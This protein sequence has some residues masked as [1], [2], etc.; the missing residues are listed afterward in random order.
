MPSTAKNTA[1][2]LVYI[3]S[4]QQP[5]DML[6]AYGLSSVQ[7]PRLD[8]LAE[9]GLLFDHAISN[10]PICT[11]A[12]GMMITGQHPLWNNCF[13]NERRLATDIGQS[14]AEVTGDAGY[15]N[16]YVGKWHLLGGDRDRPVPEGEDRHGFDDLFLTNNCALNY[17]PDNAF[18]WD[19]DQKRYFG[20]WEVEGQTDQAIDFI[21][22]QTDTQPFSLF[23]S[24]HAPHNHDGGDAARYSSFDAPEEFKDLYDPENP[25]SV[26]IR[27]TIPSNPRTRRMMQGYMALCTEVDHNVG[28]II[29]SLEEQGLLDN[30]II[31]YTSD[32]GETFGAFDNFA[33]KGSP[34]DASTRVPLI[35]RMPPGAVAARRS[36]LLVGTLD[37]MPTILGLMGIAVPDYLHGK[38]LAPHIL[39]EDDDAVTSVPLFYFATPWRGVY[40]RSWTYSVE[41]I[42]RSGE[43]LAPGDVGRTVLV[44]NLDRMY[45]HD[46]DP[47]QLFNLFGSVSMPGMEGPE[48]VQQELQRLTEEWLDYFADPFLNQKEVI[49]VSAAH[50]SRGP[51]FL[52]AGAPAQPDRALQPR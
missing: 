10:A 44:R 33:H 48:F 28:R 19:G 8:Q 25:E 15:R 9:E 3:F 34:E 40:T 39:A 13:N 5:R 38:N 1:P 42:D 52:R 20:T 43:V 29:D 51:H 24:Y 21:E 18:Y 12:R 6:G 27:P 17:D 45:N 47:H 41:N 22:Q 46:D 7:T 50:P 30:T 36:E 16:A 26:S 2:N 14:F 11:P 23:V 32:H 37:L 4:D 35:V 31:V 49:E